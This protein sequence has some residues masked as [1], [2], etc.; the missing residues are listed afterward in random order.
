MFI[1][2]TLCLLLFVLQHW[3]H[4][5]EPLPFSINEAKSWWSS[6]TTNLLI[7]SCHIVTVFLTVYKEVLS[8]NAMFVCFYMFQF[9]VFHILLNL[10]FRNMLWPIPSLLFNQILPINSNM[11]QCQDP[12]SNTKSTIHCDNL[13]S[14]V[15]CFF[16]LQHQCRCFCIILRFSWR[17]WNVIFYPLVDLWPTV[18]WCATFIFPLVP[19]SNE[20]ML[21]PT[22]MWLPWDIHETWAV[23]LSQALVLSSKQFIQ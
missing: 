7:I 11:M 1:S 3:F 15:D 18:V 16:Q 2:Y 14:V 8:L 22:W 19:I 4:I 12:S 17:I 5:F 23:W 6:C 13:A 9:L 21:V 20:E 10:I